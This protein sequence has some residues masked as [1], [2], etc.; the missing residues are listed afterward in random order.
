MLHY[1]TLAVDIVADVKADDEAKGKM[2][3]FIAEILADADAD[4]MS[5]KEQKE[6]CADIGLLLLIFSTIVSIVDLHFSGY[7]S[8][9]T[10]FVIYQ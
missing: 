9:L 4:N 6:K 8:E 2:Q 1:Q 5:K 3:K 7:L 10:T